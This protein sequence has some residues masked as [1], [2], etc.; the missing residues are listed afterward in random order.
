MWQ[1]K[2]FSNDEAVALRKNHVVRPSRLD[3]LGN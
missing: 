1:T 3:V 2:G